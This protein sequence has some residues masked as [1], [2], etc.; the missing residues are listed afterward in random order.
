MTD[1]PF[2]E[3]FSQNLRDLIGDDLAKGPMIPAETVH[4]V[5][6]TFGLDIGELMICLLP[7]AAAYARVPLSGF[8]VG[9]VA[10]GMP[11]GNLYLGSNMEF[12][13]HAL[14]FSVHGEQSAINHAWQKGEPG[15]QALAVN[16]APCGYC[17]QF[18]N[19][20]ATANTGFNILLKTN[21]DPEDYSYSMQPLAFYL[22]ESFGPSDLGMTGGLMEPVD[23]G[24]TI[25]SSDPL[26][27]DP[28]ALAALA[29]A[30]ASYAPYTS[31][32]CGVA[33]QQS[34]GTIFTGRYGE[35]AAYN[36]SFSPLESALAL[37]NMNKAPQTPYDIVAAVL[38][39]TTAKISQ[40]S[41]TEVVLS[42][43][44][45]DVTLQY[46]QAT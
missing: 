35:N 17:R 40:R 6:D 36:P 33:L 32:F 44:A 20:L 12:T 45:P 13:G 34:D 41:A 46:L 24:L 25:T 9:A 28:L 21:K 23:H 16:A 19:E 10:L 2:P 27:S 22:P 5:L 15:L 30:N 29:A 43:V 8:H 7:I 39:E 11:P 42:T 3:Y 31:D 1:F 37:L 4:Q 14:S 26:A 18:M 38:V